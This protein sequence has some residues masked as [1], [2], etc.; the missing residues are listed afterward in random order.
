MQAVPFLL[1]GSKD[2]RAPSG[3][4][5]VPGGGSWGAFWMERL[6]SGRG[7]LLRIKTVLSASLETLGRSGQLALKESLQKPFNP[8]TWDSRRDI[9]QEYRILLSILP[10]KCQTFLLQVHYSG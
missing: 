4:E 1:C 2:K 7:S 6:N 5:D 10:F 8:R 9:S 3:E